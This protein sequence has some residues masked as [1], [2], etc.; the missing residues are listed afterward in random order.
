MVPVRRGITRA[1][2]VAVGLVLGLAVPPVTTAAAGV[3][4]W[5]WVDCASAGN[6][7]GTAQS[8]PWNTLSSV[9]AHTFKA[10]D[11]LV[12]ATGTSCRGQLALRGSGASGNPIVIG[13][14]RSGHGS[15]KPI[16]AGGGVT[17]ATVYLHDNEYVT[18][19]DLEV[20]NSG[21]SAGDRAGILA[22]NDTGSTLHGITITA[23][24][25][26]NVNGYRW[27]YYG[28]NAGIAVDIDGGLANPGVYSGVTISDNAV[29]NVNR[30][31]VWVG[32]L[33]ENGAIS[34]RST[35]VT[36]SGNQMTDLGADGIVTRYTSGAQIL[37]N[38]V[39]DAGSWSGGA[40]SGSPSYYNPYPDGIW[41]VNSDNPVVQ[42]NEVFGF[43]SQGAGDGDALD[44]DLH[45]TNCLMQDNY[46]HDNVDGLWM[47]CSGAGG[48]GEVFRYNISQNDAT[49]RNGIFNNGCGGSPT[50][51]VYNNTVYIGSGSPK[52]DSANRANWGSGTAFTDNII[53]NQGNGGF[54]TSARWDHTLFH[55]SGNRPADNT[56]AV[57]GDP[58]FAHPNGA[59]NGRGTAAAAYALSSGSAAI[60]T[61]VAIAGAPGRDFSGNSVCASPDIGAMQNLCGPAGQVNNPG[62]ETGS[63]SPWTNLAG[64]GVVGDNAHTGSYAVRTGNVNSG[65]SQTVYGLASNRTY[66]L[67]G[68]VKSSNGSD[69]V[70]VGVKNYGGTETSIPATSSTYTRISVTFTTGSGS[71]SATI[72][73]WKNGGSAASY[74]DDFS[75]S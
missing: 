64:A 55:G 38:V 28:V 50:P 4:T 46:S 9:N 44:C 5:W 70:Y 69:A 43:V 3:T 59:G 31:G 36:I 74:C 35:G 54:G 40:N 73:C 47:D 25:V 19:E 33:A 68:W 24:T 10:G 34:A 71:T 23:N 20:T 11:G 15:G 62:F 8:S 56:N 57:V 66:T 17:P 1:F 2:G 26:D 37:N 16:L 52:I 29:W 14:W 21:A 22:Y 49:A 32:S 18:V 53:D 42:G 48:R 12:F 7:N 58:R 75:V 6:G 41:P 51:A 27:G 67:T 13:Q 39:Y 61:A 45:T 63:L 72:Y 30:A 65:V 60:G